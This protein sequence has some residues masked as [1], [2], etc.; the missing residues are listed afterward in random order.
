[1]R[2]TDLCLVTGATLVLIGGG[3][4]AEDAG[5]SIDEMFE[6]VSGPDAA[7]IS[8]RPRHKPPKPPKQA[9]GPPPRRRGTAPGAKAPPGVAAELKAAR[10]RAIIRA[11]FYNR[12]G[13]PWDLSMVWVSLGEHKKAIPLFDMMLRKRRCNI[14]KSPVR[15]AAKIAPH[16]LGYRGSDSYMERLGTVQFAYAWSL[17][18]LGQDRAARRLLADA[19]PKLARTEY[20]P[21]YLKN[22]KQI[23]RM[24]AEIFERT[25]ARLEELEASLAETP[26][27]DKQ[28]ELAQL[29][30]P[31]PGKE[32]TPLQWKLD[33]PLKRLEA[34][35]VM[36]ARHPEHRR[37]TRGDVHWDLYHA[38]RAFEMHEKCVGVLDE[39][40]K[41]HLKNY[42]VDS[43]Y[44][45]WAKAE[46][47][48]RL[49]VLREELGVRDAL[50]AY[51]ASVAAFKA[52]RKQFPKSWRSKVGEDGRSS[53]RGRIATL[54]RAVDRI[55][56]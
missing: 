35:L 56:R 27:G 11:N 7:P 4:S 43:G 15:D 21:D 48:A 18:N 52:F 51:R 46:T 34:L 40:M 29:C 24:T 33:I 16:P 6:A 3:A 10:M 45:L 53:V 44:A 26:D 30:S 23:V 55:L 42:Y 31:A 32:G 36:L 22:K 25:K 54:S 12:Q 50:G 13:K 47:F 37:V 39:M 14:S 2:V 19:A 9:K 38:W 17:M 20:P 1:M 8:E 41:K 5:P 49:G 28:W